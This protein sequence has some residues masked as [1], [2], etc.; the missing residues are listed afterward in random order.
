MALHIAKV[1]KGDMDVVLVRKLRAP[2]QPEL[3]IGAVD[4]SGHATTA[5]FAHQYGG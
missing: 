2:H 1:L 3:A 5:E 4:E